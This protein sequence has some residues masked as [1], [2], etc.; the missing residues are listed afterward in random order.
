VDSQPARWKSL[1][2]EKKVATVGVAR[3]KKVATVCVVWST[4]L[5]V[6][7]AILIIR[8]LVHLVATL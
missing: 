6:W 1:G 2:E 5:F 8:M 4:V 7:L 3:K